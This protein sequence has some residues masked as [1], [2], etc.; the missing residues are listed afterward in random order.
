VIILS[1]RI[2]SFR[3]CPPG[4]ATHHMGFSRTSFLPQFG[5]ASFKLNSKYSVAAATQSPPYTAHLETRSDAHPALDWS[6]RPRL[7]PAHSSMLASAVA[8]G[9]STRALLMA[10]LRCCCCCTE[11]CIAIRTPSNCRSKAMAM[12]LLEEQHVLGISKALGCC[13]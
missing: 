4:T 10:W 13:L 11:A 1:F 9:E 8:L 7:C 3:W 12:V 5:V 6:H 2:H